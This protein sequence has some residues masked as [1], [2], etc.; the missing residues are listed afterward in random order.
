VE[1]LYSQ[2]ADFLYGM[3][4]H[5]TFTFKASISDSFLDPS[6]NSVALHSTDNDSDSD[7][8]TS[9]SI[10]CLESLFQGTDKPR[11]VIALS[12][13]NATVLSRLQEWMPRDCSMSTVGAESTSISNYLQAVSEASTA[14]SGFVGHSN[15]TSHVLEWLE[16]GRRMET[17]KLG[18]EPF[19][20][21][22]LPKCSLDGQ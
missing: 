17:W 9:R 12:N 20:I 1:K 11:H 4:F 5:Q 3:L 10:E 18:R 8:M 21:S 19:Q 13:Q 6:M 16:Y 15:A 14:R 7:S 22:D 2:G